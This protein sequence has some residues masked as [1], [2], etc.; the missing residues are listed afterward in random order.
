MEKGKY[1]EDKTVNILQYLLNPDVQN[2]K[3]LKNYQ[4][5]NITTTP[6]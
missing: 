1:K 3:Q 5:K 2:S 4:T 6:E